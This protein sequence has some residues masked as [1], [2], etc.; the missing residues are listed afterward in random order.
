MAYDLRTAHT[1]KIAN[2][3]ADMATKNMLN[4]RLFFIASL[5]R[6]SW[7][8]IELEQEAIDDQGSAQ[9]SVGPLMNAVEIGADYD[10][11]PFVVG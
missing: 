3:V 6:R 2:P 11:P 9:S 7:K 4:C 10:R 1:P 5:S 8:P